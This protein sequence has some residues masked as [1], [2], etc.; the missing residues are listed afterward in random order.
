MACC[1]G[2]DMAMSWYHRVYAVYDGFLT[3]SSISE[4]LCCSAQHQEGIGCHGG[5]W[6]SSKEKCFR[7]TNRTESVLRWPKVMLEKYKFDI[8][9]DRK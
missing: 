3:S 7:K 6:L 2:L 5:R 1:R 8:N 9:L 4:F